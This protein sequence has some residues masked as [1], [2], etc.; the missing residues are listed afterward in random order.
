MCETCNQLTKTK[1][2]D[3]NHLDD[4][5]VLSLEAKLESALIDYHDAIMLDVLDSYAGYMPLNKTID[6]TSFFGTIS[7]L[8][9][10]IYLYGQNISLKV[11][12]KE[13]KD[14][15]ILASLDFWLSF[16]IAPD[17]AV[18]YAQTQWGALI[19]NIDEVTQQEVQAIVV[20]SIQEW[21]TQ[22]LL[23]QTIKD[24]FAEYN[25]VRS[26]LIARQET[27]LAL[28]GGQYNQFME[29]AKQYNQVWWKRTYTQAD[30][31]V[32]ATHQE[33]ADAWRIPADQEYPWTGTM[34]A[35]HDYN[36]RCSNDFRVF[37]PDEL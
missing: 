14:N 17:F 25:G 32:R 13:T 16:D 36:C 27:A 33:N 10:S 18:S 19:K 4:K 2:S 35:P 31:A 22:Q 28:W 21:W 30:N 11:F 1:V 6:T 26:K 20:K 23:A 5:E 29:S 3:T 12:K 9:E 15:P 34:Y 8:L 7:S 24:N 37:L